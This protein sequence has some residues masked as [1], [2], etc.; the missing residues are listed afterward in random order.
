[1]FKELK[2][3]LVNLPAHSKTSKNSKTSRNFRNSRRKT[4]KTGETREKEKLNFF[5]TAPHFQF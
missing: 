3:Y 1:M 5:I 4:R 2:E